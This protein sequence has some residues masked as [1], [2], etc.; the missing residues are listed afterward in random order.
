MSCALKW[1]GGARLVRDARMQSQQEIG[2]MWCWGQ[3]WVTEDLISRAEYVLIWIFRSI[4]PDAGLQG[5]FELTRK[6]VRRRV[7]TLLERVVWDEL[8]RQKQRQRRDKVKKWK[9]IWEVM[10]M[11]TQ[12]W[13]WLRPRE[14]GNKMVLA[15]DVGDAEGWP[16]M[17]GKDD[18]FYLK[19]VGASHEHAHNQTWNS[20]PY[21]LDW[22]DFQSTWG[23]EGKKEH[24]YRNYKTES[25]IYTSLNLI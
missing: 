15:S 10:V 19:Y 17:C 2:G 4:S 5:Q 6:S 16:S 1:R 13:N 18:G 7:I 9:Q 14:L 22:N 3:S 21:L 8:G 11:K 23:R 25:F 24:T 12:H 20:D